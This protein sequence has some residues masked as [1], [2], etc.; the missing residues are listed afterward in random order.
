[1]LRLSQVVVL[2]RCNW[3]TINIPLAPHACL[4]KLWMSLLLYSDPE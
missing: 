2:E 3:C 1:M 4:Y